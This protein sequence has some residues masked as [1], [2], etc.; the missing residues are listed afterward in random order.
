MDDVG[1]STSTP[2]AE[3]KPRLV[4]APRLLFVRTKKPGRVDAKPGF[5]SAV[6]ALMVTVS[7]T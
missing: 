2:N 4:P 7:S 5:R 1:A 3:L 6:S